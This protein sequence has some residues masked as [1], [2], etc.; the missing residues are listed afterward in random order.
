MLNIIM[1][2]RYYCCA[3]LQMC[4]LT[5]EMMKEKGLTEGA[6]KKLHKKLEELKYVC[7]L[8]LEQLTT[9]AHART[10]TWSF[11]IT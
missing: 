2:T 8:S 7:Y 9:P 6:A 10:H 1:Y 5:V 4:S 3:H 11:T